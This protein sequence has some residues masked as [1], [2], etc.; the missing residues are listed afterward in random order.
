MLAE[1]EQL[2]AAGKLEEAILKYTYILK[3][4]PK[5]VTALSQLASIYEIQKRWNEA[6]LYYRKI[7][8]INPKDYRI[9]LHLGDALRHNGNFEKAIQCYLDSVRIKPGFRSAY[10]RLSLMIKQGQLLSHDNYLNEAIELSYQAIEVGE[11]NFIINSV[12]CNALAQKGRH[13][14]SIEQNQRIVYETL[15]EN[16]PDFIE[17]AWNESANKKPNFIV[18]GYMKCGTTALYNYISQHPYILGAREKEMKFFSNDSLYD[19]GL[20]WYCSNFPPIPE[21]SGY[22]TGEA[23]PN[24]MTGGVQTAQRVCNAFPDIKLIIILRNPVKRALSH[25]YFS[26]KHSA[27]YQKYKS[28]EEAINADIEKFENKVAQPGG[29]KNLNGLSGLVLSGLYV[30]SIQEWLNLFPREQFLILRNE[31]LAKDTT[32]TMNKVFDFLGVSASV[33]L[34]CSRKNSGSYEPMSQKQY[35]RLLEF[36]KPHNQKLEDFLGINFDW[37]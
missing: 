13:Q 36:Y 25:Y 18:S 32:S 6:I 19:L 28:F 14:E 37:N 22:I 7:I 8:N 33:K 24:Y 29:V 20:P 9:Y 21:G 35:N 1:G 31:D 10:S 26:L 12:L 2:R 23:T 11:N 5:N 15:I 30:Y 34:Q 4:A 3:T 17:N 16:K 27:R